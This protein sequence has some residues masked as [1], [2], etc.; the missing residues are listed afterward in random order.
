M[1]IADFYIAMNQGRYE[2]VNAKVQQRCLMFDAEVGEKS[3]VKF[4]LFTSVPKN[5]MRFDRLK[6]VYIVN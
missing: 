2:N 3:K 5:N 1:D 6:K 4:V